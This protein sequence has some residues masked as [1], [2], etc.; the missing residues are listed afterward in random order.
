MHDRR[1]LLNSINVDWGIGN[2][3]QE[4][5]SWMETYQ[6]LVAYKK[7]H[8]NT[9]IPASC[10]EDPRL[11]YWVKKQRIGYKSKTMKKERYQ[12]LDYINFVWEIK[13]RGRPSAVAV[14]AVAETYKNTITNVQIDNSKTNDDNDTPPP[15]SPSCG[16]PI[17]HNSINN[18][19]DD[20]DEDDDG[21][22]DDD[23]DDNDEAVKKSDGNN[24]N[25]SNNVSSP[26]SSLKKRKQ[27]LK[28]DRM[29]MY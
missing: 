1:S 16:L 28:S 27:Y 18:Y 23:D 19:N 6:R 29:E 9:N 14:A 12:L 17:L 22:D 24:N 26:S 11:G 25:T 21:D 20:N 13:K 8:N 15:C 5:S 10:K 7:Q 4:N 3:T 2:R